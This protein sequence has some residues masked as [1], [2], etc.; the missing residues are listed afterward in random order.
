MNKKT[1]RPKITIGSRNTSWNEIFLSEEVSFFGGLTYHP[2]DIRAG[3]GTLVL[4]SSNIL[5]G[6][7]V[8]ADNVYVDDS[9]VNVENVRVGDI[10]VV[11]RNGS[12]ALLGKHGVIK[13]DS[14]KTVIGAFMTGIRSNDPDFYNALLNS[15][16][17]QEEIRKNLGATIN[18]ITN[19]NFKKL[20]FHIPCDPHESKEIGTYF[21]LLDDAIVA[22]SKEYSKLQNIK[23]SYRS[24]LFPRP[25]EKKP[26][27][28]FKGFTK[29][30][31]SMPLSYYASK[32][33]TKNTTGA[34]SESFTNSAEFGIISQ[35]D[36][37]E[38]EITKESNNT[39]YYVVNEDDFVYNPRISTYAP[40]GPINRNKLGRKGIM[41]PLY[42]VF[43]V[44]DIDTMFLEYYFQTTLWHHYMKMNGNTGARH[45]R[46]SISDEDFF[47]M[48]IPTPC[49]EEQMAI[50][51]LFYNLDKLISTQSR[52]IVSLKR[53]KS[54]CLAR[55][56]VY[57]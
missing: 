53:I 34:V 3:R 49:L 7:V 27:L 4:R 43:S 19:G 30:W 50:G 23:K 54:A 45:D 2:K 36:F 55:M 15:P 24:L 22:T 18:Q 35:L 52:R 13:K 32:V 28:R 41:S 33:T 21:R 51:N 44:K 56:F 9:I 46:F 6:E 40:V 48:P 25:E 17:F 11:V 20:L 12:K 42:M 47:N 31:I 39:N 38:H 16:K 14:P 26:Q 29:D 57:E 10:I 1:S 5:E 37:F 8:D